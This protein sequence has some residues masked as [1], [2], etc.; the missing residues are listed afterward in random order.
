MN[1]ML[2]E[3]HL[4]SSFA[5]VVSGRGVSGKFVA[6]EVFYDIPIYRN[7]NAGLNIG[8]YHDYYQHTLSKESVQ[9]QSPTIGFELNYREQDLFKLKGLYFTFAVP[10]RFYIQP[11]EKTQL[12]NATVNRHFFENN[13]WLF[14]GYQF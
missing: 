14:V 6:F 8:Y 5:N 2:T 12:N 10:F 3:Q 7:L 1:V 4:S 13:I 9:N 11:L